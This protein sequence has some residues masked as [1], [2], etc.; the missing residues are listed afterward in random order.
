MWPDVQAW[1]TMPRVAACLRRSGSLQPQSARQ[2][3][4]RKSTRFVALLP[5]FFLAKPAGTLNMTTRTAAAIVPMVW[6]LLGPQAMV[7]RAGEAGREQAAVVAA[8]VVFKGGTLID[9]S[10]AAAR[11]ADLAV[12]GDRIVAVGSLAI[13]AKAR[14][15]DVSSLV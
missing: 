5:L 13:D 4:R 1:V 12:R 7:G 11:Q 14:V 15:I 9:G 10:G 2:V 8:D 3:P 6:L